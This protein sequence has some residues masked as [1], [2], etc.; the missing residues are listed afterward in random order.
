VAARYNNSR[1]EDW[2]TKRPKLADTP[3]YEWSNTDI[4]E[5]TDL[6]E[7]LFARLDPAA[8]QRVRESVHELIREAR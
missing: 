7:R 6:D 1:P 8:W 5:V 4:D 3:P 2:W